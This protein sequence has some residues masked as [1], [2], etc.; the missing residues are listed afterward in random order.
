MNEL[1]CV[2]HNFITGQEA[3]QVDLVA[4]LTVEER[5]VLEELRSVLQKVPSDVA[6]LLAQ[7]GPNGDWYDPPFT[8]PA[9]P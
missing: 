6:A 8:A 2:I 5:A 3:N 1:A 9:K 4:A 7:A